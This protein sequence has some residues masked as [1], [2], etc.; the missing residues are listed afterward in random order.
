MRFSWYLMLAAS[1]PGLVGCGAAERPAANDA[2]APQDAA[3]D[4]PVE[5]ASPAR[6][7]ALGGTG[8][9]RVSVALDPALERRA[10]EVWLAARCDHGHD[11]RLVRWDRS[12]AMLLDGFGPGEYTVFASSF[13]AAPTTSARVSIDP[14]S[15]ASLSVT[16]AAEPAA[17]GTLQAGGVGVAVDAGLLVRPDASRGDVDATAPPAWTAR[18]FITDPDSGMSL[19]SVEVEA[20]PVEDLDDAASDPRVAV[21]VVVRNTCS[22]GGGGACGALALHGAEVRA[23]DGETPRGVGAGAFVS[24]SVAPGESTAME[25][26]IVLRGALPDAQHALRVAVFGA[27]PRAAR[28]AG[29]P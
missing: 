2:A 9:L 10:P 28:A 11:V 27:L 5:V 6:P 4:A 14:V 19:G 20:A 18:S 1:L 13:V 25:R 3:V 8:R 26:P 7:C 24:A 21:R 12:P 17:I 22:P 16:L 15:T 23:L 29:R